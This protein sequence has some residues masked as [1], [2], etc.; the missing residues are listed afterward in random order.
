MKFKHLPF[1]VILILGLN[2]SYISTRAIETKSVESLEIGEY[3]N[4]HPTG[5]IIRFVGESLYYDISFLWFEKAATAK[6]SFFK[7]N[8]KYFSVLEASTTG[9][10]GFFTSYRKH[11]YKT[12]FEVIDNGRTLRP[13][14]FLRQV[15]IADTIEITKHKFD[16]SRRLHTWEK[17]LNEKKIDAGQDEIP[18]EGAF[19][20]ILSSFYNIRNSVYGKLIQ[21]KKFV[22]RTIPEK[23][24]DKISVNIWSEKDK[25][26]FRIEEGRKEANLMLLN[27][28]VPKEIFK[29]ETGELM[30]WSSKH[31]I[32]V[33][34]TVKDYILLGDLHARFTHMETR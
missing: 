14:T 13:K 27:I 12:E 19:N 3:K 33:E 6:V 2:L 16:Y 8:G 11:F 31:Y 32:P 9:F 30:V 1:L 29:T 17:H 21:G 22:I 23:G 15:T 4:F 20:D 5:K 28:I 7:E 18:E 10:V 24:H 26:R 34:T 25:E